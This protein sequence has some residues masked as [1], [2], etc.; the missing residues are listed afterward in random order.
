MFV[1]ALAFMGYSRNQQALSA[2]K[3]ELSELSIEIA[4]DTSY[5]QY[6]RSMGSDINRQW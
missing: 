3:H 4:T 5:R 2:E 1:K 6:S